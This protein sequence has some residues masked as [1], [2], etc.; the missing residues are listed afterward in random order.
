MSFTNPAPMGGYITGDLI[1][2]SEIN[3]WCSILPD[4]L[5]GAGGGTYTLSAPL[6]ITGNEVEIDDLIAQF[7]ATTSGANIYGTV[8]IG[9]SSSELLTVRSTVDLQNNVTIGSSS[10]DTL[11]V[12]ATAQFDN[13]VTLG[14]SAADT[15]TLQGV[16]GY[17]ATGRILG[18]FAMLP[19][20]NTSVS[21]LQV[22]EA[23]TAATATRTYTTTGTAT[24]GDH[25]TFYNHSAF[26]QNLTGVISSAMLA[27]RVYKFCYTSGAWVAF[28]VWATA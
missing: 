16:L 15:V 11:Q 26:D 14:A 20:S 25:F 8:T 21:V 23:R 28:A 12:I 13:N 4:C 6:I 1:D 22:R 17:G 24:E 3:Y 10:G 2:D 19:D 18:T 5:D 27:S 7:L 9:S